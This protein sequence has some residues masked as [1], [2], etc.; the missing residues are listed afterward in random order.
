MRAVSGALHPYGSSTL[1]MMNSA[2]GGTSMPTR[3]SPRASSR[4]NAFRRLASVLMSASS[5]LEPSLARKIGSR[6][7]ES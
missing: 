5:Q 1:S 4:L 6:P 7:R 3:M 2:F